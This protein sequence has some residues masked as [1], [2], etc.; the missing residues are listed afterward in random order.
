MSFFH[1]VFIF[2]LTF[3]TFVFCFQSLPVAAVGLTV[4]AMKKDKSSTRSSNK[5]L[6]WRVLHLA[7]QCIT[8]SPK[9]SWYVK[10]VLDQTTKP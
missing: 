2:V 9:N 3:P 7:T 5:I 4:R 1:L 6:L 8:V 10:I